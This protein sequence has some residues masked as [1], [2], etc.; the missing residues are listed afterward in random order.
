MVTGIGINIAPLS[1]DVA[2]EYPISYL[3]IDAD[4]QE[5]LFALANELYWAW[6]DFLTRPCVCPETFARYDYLAGNML[7]ATNPNN[8]EQTIGQGSGINAQGQLLL[9]QHG[10]ITALTSQQSIRLL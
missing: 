2:S 6:Q 7:L 9:Q 4:K 8:N 3:R 1:N 5:L 10:Q